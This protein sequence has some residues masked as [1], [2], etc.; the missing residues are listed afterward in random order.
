MSYT[1][2]LPEKISLQ[3]FNHDTL[4]FE[5]SGKW[6][7]PLF[8]FEEFLN[9]YSGERDML[10]SHDSALGKAAAVLS[11][12]LGIKKINADIL[13]ENALNYIKAVNGDCA[14][15][16]SCDV[17]YTHLVP[18]LLCA[19]ENQLENLFD[20]DYMYFLLR[21][22]AKLVQGVDISVQNLEHPF[23]KKRDLSFDLRAGS[24]LMVLGENGTGKTTLLRLVCGIEKKYKG[25]ILIDGKHPRDLKKY[26]IGYIPQFTDAPLFSLSCREVVSLG[27]DSKR[28]NKNQIVESALCRVSAM[29]FADRSFSSLSGGEKQKIHLARCLAQN[30]KLLLLDEPTASLDAENKKMVMDILRSLTISEIPTIIVVTHDKELADMHGWEKLVIGEDDV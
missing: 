28:K 4:I 18:K 8:E 1:E 16:Y 6:L 30:A 27:I 15:S 21:Q 10:C 26:T 20:Q 2:P 12:R 14:K 19:T 13:S 3:I 11:I 24:H 5:S 25:K 23:I 29:D 17:K 9:T 22:R 7:N